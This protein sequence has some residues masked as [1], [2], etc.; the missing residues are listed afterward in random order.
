MNEAGMNIER[1][2]PYRVKPVRTGFRF[3]DFFVI[4]L[5][6]SGIFYCF[7][8]FRLDLFQTIQQQNVEPVGTVTVKFNTV[9][10]RIAVRVLWDRLYNESPI[11]LGDIIRVAELSSATLDIEGQQINLNEN[12]LIRIQRAPDGKTLQID[13]TEGSLDVSTN[14]EAGSL[15]LNLMGR[16]VEA[17]AGSTLNVFTGNDGMVVQVNEGAAL[18]LEESGE[19]REVHSGSILAIDTE[20]TELRQLSAVVRQP[21]AAARLLKNSE[22]LLPVNFLWDRINLEQNDFLRLE[23][24]EDRNFRR[25]IQTIND[26]TDSAQVLL[27]TGIWFWRL[28]FMD[29]A[30]ASGRFTIVDALGPELLFPINNSS[31]R[32]L[33]ELPSVRFNW[34]ETE[35]ASQYLLEVSLLPD[36]R[37]VQISVQTT[38]TSYI[39]SGIEQGTWFWRVL[40][41]FSFVYEGNPSYSEISLFSVEQNQPTT[42]EETILAEVQTIVLPEP[43]PPPP[44]PPM[45]LE[46]RLISPAHQ[47]RLAGLTVLR[48]PTIFR[49][50][51]DMEAESSRFVLSRNSNPLEQPVTEITN[52]GLTLQVNQ[53]DTGIWYWTVEA[54]SSE[55]LVSSAVPRQLEVQPIPLLSVPVNTQPLNRARIDIAALRPQRYI[56][57]SWQTVNGA[58]AY[59]FTLFE[60]TATDRRLILRNPPVNRTNWR[61]ENL[62]ILSRGTFIWQVEAVNIGQNGQ[63]DQRGILRDNIFIVDIPVP[64][65]QAIRPGVLYGQ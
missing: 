25:I 34:S 28:S 18:I 58:N 1:V 53:I 55:G 50:E 31:F 11:Y 20:V 62:N 64:E 52:P 12:T 9:Q 49:W 22:E 54:L 39:Q 10:R 43:P 40:P 38:A 13:L 19:I 37:N 21:R 57:F 3:R 56:D 15:R 5:C 47:A 14:E 33:D 44:P 16:V 32:F 26:L 23:I 51:S 59:I 27:D 46:L 7:N 65:V 29:E 30:F 60:Q 48:S 6:L 4:V 35:E 8:L 17:A 63:I 24:A 36:F 61:L 42:P 2:K 41:I 45:P